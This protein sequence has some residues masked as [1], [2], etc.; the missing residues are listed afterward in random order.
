MT[1]LSP[2]TRSLLA[3]AALVCGGMAMALL[4]AEWGAGR[5]LSQPP[6]PYPAQFFSEPSMVTNS[7]NYR[8]FEYPQEKGEKTFRIIAIG[9]SFTQGGGVNFDDIYPKRLERYLNV[10]RNIQ[11]WSYQVLNWGRPGSSTPWEVEELRNEAGKYK[12]DLIVL[13]YCLNDAEDEKDREGVLALRKK[14][15]M[16]DPARGTG[17]GGYLFDHSALY[18]LVRTRIHN[19]RVNRGQIAY[20][21]ALYHEEYAGWRKSRA[22]LDDLKRFRDESGIPVLVMIFPLFAW[23]LAEGYPFPDV[24]GKLH[25]ELD[26]AGLP[27]LDLLPFYRGL[28]HR[29]LEAIPFVDPHPSDVAHRIAA[30]NLYR[31]LVKARLLPRGPKTAAEPRFRKLRPPY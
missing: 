19:S 6:R 9:D 3:N 7:N 31:Y 20:Y 27:Y 2:K 1:P 21:Q 4:P 16:L 26:R 29:P 13:A 5:L 25:Q 12:P 17:L 22:A 30:E 23:D 10:Y 24:H 15:R 11:G 8:D 28:D 18:R 14:Y